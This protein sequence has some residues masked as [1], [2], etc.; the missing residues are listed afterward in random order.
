M[1]FG[2]ELWLVWGPRVCHSQ[3]FV[4]YGYTCCSR[5]VS[6]PYFAPLDPTE[7][8]VSTELAELDAELPGKLLREVCNTFGHNFPLLL[9]Q[10]GPSALKTWNPLV[11]F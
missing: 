5:L 10:N 3:L 9:N 1:R 2:G 4:Q 6:V 11:Q 7:P 8:L